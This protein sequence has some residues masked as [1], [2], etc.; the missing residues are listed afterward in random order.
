ML[1]LPFEVG[2]YALALP[3]ERV[4][5]V[6][7]MAQITPL[8]RPTANVAGGIVYGG[9]PVAVYDFRRK[10]GLPARPPQATDR[11]VL[12]RAA[13]ETVAIAADAVAPVATVALPAEDE[14]RRARAAGAVVLAGRIVLLADLDG[15][16][17]EAE[18][19]ELT[20][21]LGELTP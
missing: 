2:R 5:R 11:L 20:A 3:L 4:R 18:G 1:V 16:L 19:R 14:P 7:A 9:R 6:E 17:D 12:A 15:F 8:A 21:A 13:G 10:L